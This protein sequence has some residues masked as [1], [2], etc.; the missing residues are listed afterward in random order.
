MDEGSSGRWSTQGETLDQVLEVRW[1]PPS[2]V[3]IV[4]P[5]PKKA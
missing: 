1:D 3:S 5:S 2:T 4:A